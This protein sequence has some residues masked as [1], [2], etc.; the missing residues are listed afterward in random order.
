MNEKAHRKQGLG[1]PSHD[2]DEP[3]WSNFGG[4]LGSTWGTQPGKHISSS[5]P[6]LSYV[7]YFSAP[8]RP[9]FLYNLV[10]PASRANPL[11]WTYNNTIFATLVANEP[12]PKVSTLSTMYR[13]GL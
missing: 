4:N 1:R 13:T 10:V 9:L 6:N 12:P 7:L 8:T 3:V 2:D 5:P 11:S